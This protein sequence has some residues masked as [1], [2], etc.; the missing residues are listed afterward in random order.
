MELVDAMR[1][2]VTKGTGA[3]I[4]KRYKITAD[5]AGKTGTTQEN[6]DAWFIMMH[7][8]LVA[9]ARVGYNEKRS[10][11]PWGTGARGA[12]PIVGDVFQQALK[13]GWIDSRAEFGKEP[14]ILPY[15]WV[16]D[17]RLGW[18]TAKTIFTGLKK[19]LQSVLK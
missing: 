5:V 3:A 4:R 18:A 7:P 16:Q 9:G 10:M 8:E 12:L 14:P 15:Q 13:N 6:H 19:Q 11:G 2:V 1:G 17:R